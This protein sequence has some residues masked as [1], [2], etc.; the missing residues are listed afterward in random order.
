MYRAFTEHA[1]DLD[2]VQLAVAGRRTADTILPVARN[3]RDLG[4]VALAAVPVFLNCLDVANIYNRS[5][6][7]GDFCFPQK[8]YEALACQVPAVFAVDL[9]IPS[10]NDQARLLL[11]LMQSVLRDR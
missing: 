5:S 7:F 11:Q 10:W 8:F 1:A 4:Q 2:G 3:F 9:D 6:T